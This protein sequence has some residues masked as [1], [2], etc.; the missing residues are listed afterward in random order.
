MLKFLCFAVLLAICGR[1]RAQT[2]NLGSQTAPANAPASGG[3]SIV[4]RGPFSRLWQQTVLTTN[5][6]GE[7]STNFQT[8]TEL[9][10]GI[11]YPD[12]ATGEWLDSVE[13]VQGVPGGAAATQGRHKVFWAMNANTPTG[14]VVVN[15]P[16]G[17]TLTSTV[18]GLAYWEPA[19]DKS[20]L[21]AP[22]QNSDGVIVGNN[23]VVYSN[24]FGTNIL[25][26]LKNI[27]LAG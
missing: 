20:A 6:S 22:L 23:Q 3:Y 5:V 19:S 26:P 12:P 18:Y 10:T 4:Q 9:G 2:A 1:S 17:K 8:Y 16:D 14:A 24:V 11:C 15:T 21:I 13:Q 7:V 27:V 25:R